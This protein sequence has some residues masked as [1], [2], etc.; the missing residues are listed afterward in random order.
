[1]C[2][3]LAAI[4]TADTPADPISGLIF[5]FDSLDMI[6]PIRSPP[7]VPNANANTPI[8]II[9]NVLVL[10]NTS[11]VALLPTITPRI[12]V[13]ILISSFLAV[14]VSLGTTSDY[15]IKLPSINIPRS[16]IADGKIIPTIPVTAI[17]KTIF[18]VL[19]TGRSCS[20]TIPLSF[21]EVR[22][23]IIGG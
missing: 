14:F 16:G 2:D 9:N 7:V 15:F 12:I 5:P 4:G 10:R 6:F 17:G 20:I 3:I 13:I 11:A 22:S 21:L 23:F 18:S 19:D 8:R 1:M